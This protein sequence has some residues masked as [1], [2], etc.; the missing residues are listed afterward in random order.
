[1][2]VFSFCCIDFLYPR[3]VGKSEVVYSRQLQR[4]VV[5]GEFRDILSEERLFHPF[6]GQCAFRLQ[7]EM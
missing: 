1:M 6:S 5:R 7:R 3:T 2:F 4:V